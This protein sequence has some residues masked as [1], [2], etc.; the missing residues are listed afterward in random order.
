MI[1][2]SNLKDLWEEKVEE[3]FVLIVLEAQEIE[4]FRFELKTEFSEFRKITF[5]LEIFLE[6]SIKAIVIS[7]IIKLYIDLLL[8]SSCFYSQKQ[9]LLS[10]F[11]HKSST[12]SYNK[13]CTTS[14]KQRVGR[15]PLQK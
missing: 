7:G 15:F 14:E 11:N 2:L 3:E 9:T 5:L 12:K 13:E 8:T 10:R 1:F 6:F 4:V